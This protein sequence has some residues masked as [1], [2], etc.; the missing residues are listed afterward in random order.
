MVFLMGKYVM[1]VLYTFYRPWDMKKIDSGNYIGI[2]FL[3]E[4]C[5]IKLYPDEENSIGQ[6]YTAIINRNEAIELQSMMNYNK[7]L[8]IDLMDSNCTDSLIIRIT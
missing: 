3:D 4:D 1:S 7:S 8:F 2:P 6:C 5:H